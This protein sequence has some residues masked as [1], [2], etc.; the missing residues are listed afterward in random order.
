V[1]YVVTTSITTSDI[2]LR[3][4][5]IIHDRLDSRGEHVLSRLFRV[6]AGVAL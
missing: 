6:H 2:M 3:G 5:G 4:E 1:S